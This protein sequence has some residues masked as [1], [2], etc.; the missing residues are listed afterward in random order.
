[1]MRSYKTFKSKYDI[2]FF[3]I[4]AARR[5]YSRN[6]VTSCFVIIA[7]ELFGLS[8]QNVITNNNIDFI[9]FLQANTS[10]NIVQLA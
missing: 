7:L 1:M 3:M 9:R 10:E 8:E 5:C 6:N 2:G 4:V